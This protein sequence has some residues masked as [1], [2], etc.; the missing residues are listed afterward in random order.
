[1]WKFGVLMFLVG[2]ERLEGPGISPAVL[3]P[4]A[5]LVP[6][7]DLYQRGFTQPVLD[8]DWWWHPSVIA[9]RSHLSAQAREGDK[10]QPS[11]R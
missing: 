4:L 3:G 10:A 7:V 8:L 9:W 2:K 11:S 6:H 1:M 5:G